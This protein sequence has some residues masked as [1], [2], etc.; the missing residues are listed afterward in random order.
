M[1]NRRCPTGNALVAPA[2]QPFGIAA[3]GGPAAVTG[4]AGTRLVTDPGL[5]PPGNY[6]IIRN[7]TG[8]GVPAPIP[9]NTDIVLPSHDRHRSST[10]L[11][12][13]PG[14]HGKT[15]VRGTAPTESETR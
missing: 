15:A 7:S 1:G 3:A 5:G 8:P 14:A 4:I 9:G 10:E 13:P 11:R 2:R 12:T 6:G